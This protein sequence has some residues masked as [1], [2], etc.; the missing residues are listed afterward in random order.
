MASTKII[1]KYNFGLD[2]LKSVKDIKDNYVVLM[3]D[4][5]SSFSTNLK[6]KVSYLSDY[7][8]IKHDTNIGIIQEQLGSMQQQLV[9]MQQQL[10]ALQDENSLLK[11]RINACE[12]LLSND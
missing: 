4:N 8:S 7:I 3:N 9:S 6:V 2:E 10:T 5:D 1:D 11:K 12:I